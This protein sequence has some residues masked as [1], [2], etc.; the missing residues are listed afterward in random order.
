MKRWAIVVLLALALAALLLWGVGPSFRPCAPECTN[1]YP[2][3]LSDCGGGVP[4][5]V[6]E[7]PSR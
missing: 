2:W 4:V 1:A 3:C 7:T 6:G 5:L